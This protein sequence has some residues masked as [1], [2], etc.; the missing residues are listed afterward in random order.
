M[1]RRR[2]HDRE[3]PGAVVVELRSRRPRAQR[4][5]SGYAARQPGRR[6]VPVGPGR[7]VY[8]LE[9]EDL[10]PQR[11]WRLVAEGAA[12]AWDPCGCDAA[13]CR[14][15]FDRDERADLVAAGPPQGHAEGLHLW[16]N[17]SG[18]HAVLVDEWVVWGDLM[19]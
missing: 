16:T 8:D 5:S 9:G 12:V 17:S 6:V 4:E 18:Q 1:G 14:R 3:G 15:W 2:Q 19:G 11:A 7:V 10:S 13:G